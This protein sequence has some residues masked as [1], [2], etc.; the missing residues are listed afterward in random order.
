MNGRRRLDCGMHMCQWVYSVDVAAERA[1]QSMC[2][3][4][5]LDGLSH[6]FKS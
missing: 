6:D 5:D 2:A 1:H 3:V 4:H